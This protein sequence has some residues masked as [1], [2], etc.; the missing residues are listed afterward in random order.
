M[1]RNLV[2]V[3]SGIVVLLVMLPRAF[4]QRP[5]TGGTVAKNAALVI[6][7]CGVS[8]ALQVLVAKIM[9]NQL[10]AVPLVLLIPI[11]FVCLVFYAAAHF[12]RLHQ[13]ELSQV[14]YCCAQLFPAFDWRLPLY[15]LFVQV[16]FGHLV[17]CFD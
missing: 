16:R 11:A 17:C 10:V 6:A 13:N 1:S 7:A 8:V 3:I 5:L 4:R 15:S 2:P 9:M 14:G 12:G